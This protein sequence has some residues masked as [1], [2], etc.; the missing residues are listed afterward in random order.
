M[1]ILE[2]DQP[3]QFVQ[4]A[5]QIGHAAFQ[6]G[7]VA[8]RRIQAF[9]GHGQLVA[10]ILAIARST[11]ATGL[12][13]LG[14][15]QAEAVLACRLGRSQFIAGTAGGIHLLTPLR[16]GAAPLAPRGVLRRHFGDRRRLCQAGTLHGVGQ[17]QY[18]AGFQAVDIAIDK[19]ARIQRL[20]RQHGL[21]DRSAITVACGNFPKGIA[22][23]G[24]VFGGL[25]GRRRGRG[26]CI[27]CRCIAWRCRRSHSGWW[28]GR[29][30][31]GRIEQHAVV[32]HQAAVRPLHLDQQP[33]ITFGQRLL[34]RHADQAATT[35]IEDRGEGQVIEKLFAID[36][37]I[38]EG[39][40]RCQ[41]RHHIG[42]IE[43]A[44][45]EQFD[46]RQER[47]VRSRLE[48]QFPQLE[49]LRHT[50][51]QRRGGRYC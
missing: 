32:A 21:L 28:G 42:D 38:T 50:G 26:R 35:G 31:L 39:L 27:R 11:L 1:V 12:A 19:R 3:L 24:F 45:I 40:G 13:G 47:L 2:F 41:A 5:L 15:N 16:P 25:A 23:S 6:L 43:A 14:G 33:Q 30:I 9:L 10:D 20:D 46:F 4:L 44:N 18:L 8:P 29:R 17:A 7:I 36:P 48:G 22:R 51:G 34:G 37:R 49:C